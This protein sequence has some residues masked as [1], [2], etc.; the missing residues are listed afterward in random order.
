MK[1]RLSSVILVALV[2]AVF[3]GLGGGK[4]FMH[5][6]A[7]ELGI[8]IIIT[9][10][11][12]AS[13]LSAFRLQGGQWCLWVSTGPSF[14]FFVMV[15]W[16]LTFSFK[17]DASLMPSVLASREF[18]LLLLG[19]TLYLL[20]RSGLRLEQI[21]RAV[22]VG[23]LL[24]TLSYLF[25]YHTLDLKAAYFSE[26][27]FT[28]HLVTYDEAR[29]F[30]LKPP[31]YAV[32][33][34]ALISLFTLFGK[35]RLS[36]KLLALVGIGLAVYIWTLVALRAV[37]A[38]TL[39][40]LILYPLLWRRP[41]NMYLV[42]TLVP[43]IPVVT[44]ALVDPMLAYVQQSH[45]AE[46]RMEAYDLALTEIKSNWLFGWGQASGYTKTYQD[47]F[48]PKF[49]PSDLGIVGIM[50]KYGVAGALIYLIAC[51]LIL[52]KAARAHWMIS[53]LKGR[54]N[55]LFQSLTVF[56]TTMTLNIVLW[57]GLAYGQG[58]T[59]AAITLGLSACV[60]HEY[61][62]RVSHSPKPDNS[63]APEGL[64]PAT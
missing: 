21:G 58:L 18:L 46:V 45:G 49:F 63:P 39:F 61:R 30:R 37:A 17:A 19:P 6:R 59:T 60:L 62:E 41:G 16:S 42:V 7:Q 31:T 5:N 44:Y 50:F 24:A 36:M 51:P 55:P 34:L 8:A 3:A 56:M 53:A 33:L 23:L 29:G 52:L 54:P 32:M 12:G 47:V 27:P 26:D 13:F 35:S 40:A 15:F 22:I 10:F 14:V 1:F 4:F 38:G 20:Y 2:A 11:L 48:G 28:H 57:P 64:L 43:L 9:L 25:F